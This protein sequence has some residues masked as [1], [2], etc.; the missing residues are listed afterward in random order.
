[1]NKKYLVFIIPCLILIIVCLLYLFSPHKNTNTEPQSKIQS[2]IQKTFQAVKINP[3]KSKQDKQDIFIST[4]P[5]PTTIPITGLISNPRVTLVVDEI[6]PESVKKQAQN[7][8]SQNTYQHPQ[9]HYS[10]KYPSSWKAETAGAPYPDYDGYLDAKIYPFGNQTRI[11][12]YQSTPE[13]VIR[14]ED[15]DKNLNDYFETD[16]LGK[17]HAEKLQ[18]TTINSTPALI[19]DWT[20]DSATSQTTALFIKNG[21][22]YKI[23]LTWSSEDQKNQSL[24]EFVSIYQSFSN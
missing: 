7:V 3:F 24:D 2:A 19:Y 5:N 17:Q 18:N 11:S 8:D 10:V 16:P 20:F 22:A 15:T 1:M 9:L 21:K 12:Q 23:Q 13:V 14:A 4:Y 6:I